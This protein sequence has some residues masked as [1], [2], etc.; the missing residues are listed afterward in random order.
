MCQKECQGNIGQNHV[1][2]QKVKEVH[3]TIPPSEIIGRP[4]SNRVLH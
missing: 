4:R 3:P 1:I 2:C